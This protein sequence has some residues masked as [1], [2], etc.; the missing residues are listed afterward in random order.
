VG[1]IP[2]V[3]QALAAELAELRDLLAALTDADWDRPS[4][5]E[6][7]S[8][9]DVVL[10]LAQ[11]NE[12]AIASAG[13]RFDEVV[14]A[15]TAGTTAQ[16]V[17]EG[18]AIAVEKE[19]GQPNEAVLARWQASA[20]TLWDALEAADP[21]ARV[22]W[23]E[24]RVSIRTL[25]TT[26]LAETWIHAGDIAKAVGVERVPTDRLWHLGRLA[27]RTLPYAFAR[28]GRELSG[29]V[30]FELAAPDDKDVWNFLPDT[31][32]TTRISGQAGEL[33]LVAARRVDP[34]DTGLTGTGPDVTAV[35]DLVRTYA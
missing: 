29:P 20:D 31:E 17:D 12:M 7:W 23:V 9:S 34:S 8:V 25:T 13:G 22:T 27:W 11:T 28:A 26:R 2:D 15:M 33:C 30:A 18:A 4:P 32:A 1:A 14:A 16:D 24:G 19:R 5:C 6:G 35:L 10:H 21:H 3:N